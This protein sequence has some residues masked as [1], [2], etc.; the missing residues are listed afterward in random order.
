MPGSVEGK[1][2]VATIAAN[3]R[4]SIFLETHVKRITLAVALSLPILASAQASSPG[5]SASRAE[6]KQET[7]E[8]MKAGAI[9]RGEAPGRENPTTPSELPRAKVKA[10]AKAAENAPWQPKREF[11]TEASHTTNISTVQRADV[12]AETKEA[13]MKGQ[14]PRGEAEVVPGR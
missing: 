4:G 6:V 9:P 11:G 5:D 2:R 3:L 12:K 1:R 8:A 14:I 10:E 13:E 7:R